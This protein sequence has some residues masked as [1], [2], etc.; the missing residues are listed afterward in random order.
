RNNSKDTDQVLCKL[1][2][3]IKLYY[4]KHIKTSQFKGKNKVNNMNISIYSRLKVTRYKKEEHFYHLPAMTLV[5]YFCSI[6]GVVGMWIG[7]HVWL[8]LKHLILMISNIKIFSNL[9]K[10]FKS[11]ILFLC[12]STCIFQA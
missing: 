5:D 6:G 7:H 8:Y 12:F 11:F 4:A 9:S 2:C 1:D 10:R 3:E